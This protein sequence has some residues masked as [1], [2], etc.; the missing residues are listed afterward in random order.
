MGIHRQGRIVL[1][2][3]TTSMRLD[4]ALS[5]GILA[6][7]LERFTHTYE[8]YVSMFVSPG[9]IR[10]S[11][12]PGLEALLERQELVS[13]P[14]LERDSSRM[15]QGTQGRHDLNINATANPPCAGEG[16]YSRSEAFTR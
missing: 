4:I 14:D 7:Y 11:N 9:H 15:P 3:K 10:G 16:L 5:R 6:R 1:Q 8:R 12:D 2:I 13:K